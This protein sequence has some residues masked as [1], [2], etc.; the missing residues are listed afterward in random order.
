MAKKYQEKEDKFAALLE[1][2]KLLFLAHLEEHK[3]SS[4]TVNAEL[5]E[6]EESDDWNSYTVQQIKEIL[7]GCGLRNCGT[8]DG[9]LERLRS[10]EKEHRFEVNKQRDI[11]LAKFKEAKPSSSK[12]GRHQK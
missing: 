4:L 2:Q 3:A 10:Y 8:K 1:E 12:S 11:C 6:D 7:G 9:L 5:S